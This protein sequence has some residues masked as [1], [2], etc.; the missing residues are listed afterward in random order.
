MEWGELDEPAFG[1]RRWAPTMV[2]DLLKRDSWSDA[3]RG[4]F[5]AVAHRRRAEI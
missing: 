1:E 5:L 2:D 4:R 3:P